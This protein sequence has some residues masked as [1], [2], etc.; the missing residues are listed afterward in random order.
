[1]TPSPRG[2]ALCRALAAAI[3]RTDIDLA[4]L[5][6]RSLALGGDWSRKQFA[7]I[8]ADGVE[9][10]D[11]DYDVIAQAL[12]EWHMDFGRNERVAYAETL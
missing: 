8:F 1:M 10:S 12:N 6:A 2:T 11:H 5:W 4:E 9:L 3:E 7:T